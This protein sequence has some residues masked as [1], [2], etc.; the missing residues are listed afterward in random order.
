MRYPVIAGR[1]WPLRQ[2]GDWLSGRAPRSHRGGRWFDSTIAHTGQR[3][4]A[5]SRT[6]FLLPRTAQEYSNVQPSS[7][8]P[9]RLSALLVLAEGTSL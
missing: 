4:V 7:C 8:W 1:F 6:A 2:P 3:P 9:S 5:I